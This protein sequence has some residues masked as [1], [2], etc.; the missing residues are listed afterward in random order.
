MPPVT[1]ARTIDL[2]NPFAPLD[3]MCELLLVRHGE[4]LL[5]GD[6]TVYEAIDPPLSPLGERQ[7]EAVGRRLAGTPIAAVYS[8]P[9]H[10]AFATGRA[11]GGHHGLE[12]V[13]MPELHE[14]HPWAALPDDR[15]VREVLP[16]EQLS[17]IFREH[18]RTKSFAAF[19]HGED[20]QAFRK[21]VTTALGELVDRHLGE[22]IV[23]TC[24][25]GVV[26][27]FLA[28]VVDT[29]QDVPVR[30]HHTSISVFRGADT[31]R[32]VISVN[33]FAHVLPFQDAVGTYNI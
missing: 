22:R 27:A 3:G 7:V 18:A 28:S 33:D 20:R 6:T 2:E 26:N 25:S 19:P 15:P 30:V 24:H 31:R 11:I 12:P 8:S 14:Y 23:V 21:R 16:A 29:D 32:A 4:Q 17:A 9:L 1:R 5:S 10:R 13:P